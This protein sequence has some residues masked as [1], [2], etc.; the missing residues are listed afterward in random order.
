MPKI[1]LKIK[2][3]NRKSI[4]K[5]LKILPKNLL[6]QKLK[7]CV[8]PAMPQEPKYTKSCK[9]HVDKSNYIQKFRF[10]DKKYFVSTKM[11]FSI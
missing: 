4:F 7:N 10:F 5:K 9:K 2:P 11:F 3:E 8:S 1:C 6:I